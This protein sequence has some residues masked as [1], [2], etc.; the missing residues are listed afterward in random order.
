MPQPSQFDYSLIK[1]RLRLFISILIIALIVSAFSYAI[2][3]DTLNTTTEQT[4]MLFA[5]IIAEQATT[6]RSVYAEHVVSKLKKDGF[7]ANARSEKFQGHVPLPD[8]FIKQLSV[9]SILTNSDLF[10]YELVSKWHIEP[11]QGL[12]DNFENWAWRQLESQD[13]YKPDGPI[14]WKPVS[15]TEDWQGKRYFRYMQADPASDKSCVECHNRQLKKKSIS[16]QLK[17]EGT[18]GAKIFKQHQLLGAISVTIPLDVIQQTTVTEAQQSTLWTSMI[19]IAALIIVG[20]IFIANTIPYTNRQKLSWD[21]TH[22]KETGLLSLTGLEHKLSSA[23]DSAKTNSIQ[24]QFICLKL[25]DKKSIKE[26]FG[27]G[28]YNKLRIKLAEN[29]TNSLRQHDTLG[30]LSYNKLAV[31]IYDCDSKQAKKLV[32]QLRRVITETRA[33]IEGIELHL[34]STISLIAITA[35]T[36]S[37]SSIIKSTDR[38]DNEIVPSNS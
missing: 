10:R 5:K 4:A 2:L 8:Q 34:D 22:E 30:W 9:E 1:N 36:I 17:S 20:G 3:K 24:H 16:T 13:Q 15:W 7:G 19:L 23:I 12:N 38:I 26:K 31:L 25:V 14:D 37:V 18:V 21:E 29:V 11:T 32:V 6:T 35:D 33:T 27:Q 28:T